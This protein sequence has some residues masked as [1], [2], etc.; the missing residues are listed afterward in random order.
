MN[1]RARLLLAFALAA[2]LPACTSLSGVQRARVDQVTEAARVATVSCERGDACAT[3]SPLHDLSARAFAQSTPGQ[4]RHYALILDAGTDALVS[5]INLVR[6][7]TTAVDLQ[8]YIFDEDDAARLVLDELLAAAQRGVRVRVLI[9]QMA[10]L[11]RVETLAALA[12][13]HR[14]FE[15]RVY[16]PVLGRARIN[17]WQYVV[18][19]ACC[20]RKL[21]Q[22][23]HT[24]LL[25]VDGAVAITGGRNYQDDYYDWDDEYNFRDRDVLVAGPIV[26]AMASD[27]DA[28]WDDRRSK[29]V[30]HLVDVGRHL[31]DNGASALEP[32]QFERPARAQRMRDAS[33]DAEQARALADRAIP[34][35]DVRYI[36][37][38]PDKHREEGADG[39]VASRSLRELIESSQRE[40]LLQTPYLVLSKAAQDTF[41]TLQRREQPPRVVVSTNSLASTDAFIAYALSYKY[42]R[43]YLR[44]FGFEIYEYKPFPTDAPID[45]AQTGALPPLADVPMDAGDAAADAPPSTAIG[46]VVHGAGTGETGG[47]APIAGTDAGAGAEVAGAADGA[48]DP[49]APA[50]AVAPAAPLP[51]AQSGSAAGAVPVAAPPAA[52]RVRERP[53]R[54]SVLWRGSS[55]RRDFRPRLS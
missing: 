55:G 46:A 34:V 2:L 43:R 24:K 41:R 27:F 47:S 1:A 53:D 18:G 11:R 20:F 21:N 44:E 40:V 12:A 39:A 16:N 31:L 45:L 5:R 13:A 17:Y 28:F 14:N 38:L 32:A 8:T 6:S 23:M 7:A 30:R 52:T 37:D 9:D 54:R 4:P 19:T 35:G 49:T 42:K 50:L 26:R 36:S 29:P 51:A 48:V 22:R 25:V 33:A 15:L 10:A 3:P